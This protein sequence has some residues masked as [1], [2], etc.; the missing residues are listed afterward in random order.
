VRP[1]VV[2]RHLSGCQTA[3]SVISSD[4]GESWAYFLRWP[5]PSCCAGCLTRIRPFI[6]AFSKLASLAPRLSS[7]L[8]DELKAPS[9]ALY[10][11]FAPNNAAVDA[12]VAKLG[13][14][15]PKILGNSTIVTNLLSYHVVLGV[16][17]QAAM[18]TDNENLVTDYR[19]K[20]L[21]VELRSGSVYIKAKGSEARGA[22]APLR[23]QRQ[24]CTL[25][26]SLTL[27]LVQSCVPTS[28]SVT[29][30]FMRSILSWLRTP[31]QCR[32]R[33]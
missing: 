33:R 14:K 24:R 23:Q 17:A 5:R 3:L 4:P 21:Q 9:G 8:V 20:P 29:E 26:R 12:L 11:I 13:D 18:L 27:P 31:S 1:V 19:G 10:T 16:A 7:M 30:S 22:Q 6:E 28:Q 2:G 25:P 15:A 32:V